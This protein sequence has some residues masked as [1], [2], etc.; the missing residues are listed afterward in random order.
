MNPMYANP[1]YHQ[2]IFRNEFY[3][4]I[5]N[6]GSMTMAQWASDLASGQLDNLGP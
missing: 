6:S 3:Q 4:A 5:T 1:T 2:H